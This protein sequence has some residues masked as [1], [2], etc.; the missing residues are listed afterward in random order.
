MQPY[1]R[2]G[3]DTEAKPVNKTNLILDIMKLLL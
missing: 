1:L 2:S 3:T